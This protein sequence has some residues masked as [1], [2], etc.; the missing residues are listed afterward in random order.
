MA[1]SPQALPTRGMAAVASES[2][3][4]GEVSK[5]KDACVSD[6]H[7]LPWPSGWCLAQSTRGYRWVCAENYAI[8]ARQRGVH[9]RCADGG[10][11]LE[12]L[13]EGGGSCKVARQLGGEQ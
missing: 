6:A 13:A 12:R 11:A 4:R 1:G 10:N 2:W 3:A 7:S 9:K 5:G 8:E